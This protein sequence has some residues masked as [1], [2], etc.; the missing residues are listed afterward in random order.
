[1]R[2]LHLALILFLQLMAGWAGPVS[3]EESLRRLDSDMSEQQTS[4]SRISDVERQ[5][6]SYDREIFLELVK[7]AEF[8]IRYQQTVNH[9]ARWR[10]VG[11]PLGQEATYAC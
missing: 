11:Y 7:L 5:I 6:R 9:Y 8:N 2:F 10:T 4:S 3:A 1:M